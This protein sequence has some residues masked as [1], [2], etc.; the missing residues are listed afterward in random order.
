MS[1]TP[2]RCTSTQRFT[3]T[4]TH[5]SRSATWTRTPATYATTLRS[6]KSLFTVI[7]CIGWLSVSSLHS[8]PNRGSPARY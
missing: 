6:A 8:T 4:L 5:S 2:I 3:R 7:A 1:S